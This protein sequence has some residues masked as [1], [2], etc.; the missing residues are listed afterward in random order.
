MAFRFPLQEILHYRE[1]L[2]HQQELRL[3]AIHQQVAKVRHLIE[4]V[5]QRIRDVQTRES[6]ELHA[7]TTAAELCF[8][9]ASEASLRQQRQI[10]EREL[11]RLQNLRDQQQRVFQQARRDRETFEN[12]RQRQFEEYQRNAARREQRQLDEL[13]LLRRVLQHS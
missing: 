2:E 10:V 13:F 9:L 6:Q 4:Q 1:S 8:A 12:L 5:D 11:V 7:G 3:R